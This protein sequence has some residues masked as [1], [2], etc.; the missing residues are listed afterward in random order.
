MTKQQE[1]AANARPEVQPESTTD[2]Q[3]DTGIVGSTTGRSIFSIQTLDPAAKRET[4]AG[5]SRFR[6]RFRRN[7]DR[8]F[9]RVAAAG[10][11][12]AYDVASTN[13]NKRPTGPIPASFRLRRRREPKQLTSGAIVTAGRIPADGK[14]IRLYISH[15]KNYSLNRIAM[16]HW[17]AKASQR[18][19]PK[20]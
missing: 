9:R 4:A 16:F 15:L 1:V 11:A 8:H 13:R 7:S 10:R 20:L 19:S 17:P 12:A 6:T 14:P 5:T 2:S 18:S 3:F